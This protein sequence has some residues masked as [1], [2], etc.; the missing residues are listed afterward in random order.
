LAWQDIKTG[1][2]DK[3]TTRLHLLATRLLEEGH[4]NMA[5]RVLS[6]ADRLMTRG[7]MS[8]EGRKALKYGTRALLEESRTVDQP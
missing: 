1:D 8:G 5:Q 2:I 6:E 4:T 7:S 3:A